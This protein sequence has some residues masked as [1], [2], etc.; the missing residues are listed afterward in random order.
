M[1]LD[2]ERSL[3]QIE[4]PTGSRLVRLSPVPDDA[5]Y[6]LDRS[7]SPVELDHKEIPL[8]QRKKDVIL[9]TPCRSVLHDRSDPAD[10]TPRTAGVSPLARR[11]A[12][13]E[14]TRNSTASDIFDS[15][16][17]T[18]LKPRP[19]VPR[20]TATIPMPLLP[21]TLPESETLKAWV[22]AN[23]H[24]D[25]TPLKLPPDPPPRSGV[26]SRGPDGGSVSEGSS[27]RTFI[28]KDGLPRSRLTE[29]TNHDR[30][31]ASCESLFESPIFEGG[32]DDV[33]VKSILVNR[34][35]SLP[36]ISET[37]LVVDS[38]RKRRGVVFDDTTFALNTPP[39]EEE[40]TA[41]STWSVDAIAP[42]TLKRQKVVRRRRERRKH[43]I[44]ELSGAGR[45][46]L[47]LPDG[48]PSPPSPPDLALPLRSA[49]SRLSD[50]LTPALTS[51]SNKID[52]EADSSSTG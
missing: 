34:Y 7:P 33:R 27:A 26:G 46:G 44:S 36:S 19:S 42:S 35:S 24:L 43:A 45:L 5:V 18:P 30:N 20:T 29:P 9:S 41:S 31:S 11:F 37:G 39:S 10:V 40:K 14:L 51:S 25:T 3:F 13:L 28:V 12:F 47:T 15:P 52:Y 32:S 2:A 1:C 4:Y 23:R 8:E 38:S 48:I 49:S 6:F 21:P 16:D 50:S 22:E 17:E